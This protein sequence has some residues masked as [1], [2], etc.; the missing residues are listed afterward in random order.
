MGAGCSRLIKKIQ[1]LMEERVPQI[2]D[3][4]PFCYV[5]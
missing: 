3:F 5:Y 1:I 2:G 4:Y